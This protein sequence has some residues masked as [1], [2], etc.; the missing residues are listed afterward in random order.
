MGQGGQAGLYLDMHVAI[1]EDVAWLE[2][3]VEQGRLDAVEKVHSQAGLMD[4]VELE[5]RGEAVCGQHLLQGA[6]GHE[7]HHNAKG[8]DMACGNLIISILAA[9]SMK[10]STS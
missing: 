1:K 9:S 5:P 2:V 7:L 10:C 8:M 4:D 6:T 3:Q